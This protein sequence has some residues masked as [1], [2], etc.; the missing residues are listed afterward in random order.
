MKV[1]RMVIVLLTL[2]SVLFFESR[3]ISAEYNQNVSAK[4]AILIEQESG[5]IL[6]EKDARSP[7]RI[8]SITKIMTAILAIESGNL[9]EKV[10]VSSRAFS[11]EGSSIYLTEGEEIPLR[12]LI[13]GLMLRSGNDA[14]VAIAEHVGGS[15]E[16]FV[17]MMNEKASEI[18][19]EQTIFANP[20]GLDDHEE[21]YSSALDMALLTQYAMENETYKE[22]TSTKSYRSDSDK[23]HI[24]VF[25][26]KNR[27]LTQLYPYAIGGKTGYTKRA[28]RT[29]VS[30][31]EK[32]GLELIA[33]TIDA[34]SDW[35][36]HMNL[37]DWGFANFQ[38]KTLVKKG[39]VKD[40][41]D[42]Y[43]KNHLEAEFSFEFPL[44]EDEH[45]QIKTK[46]MLLSPSN[47]AEWEE[48]GHP[49]PIGTV[50]IDLS[51][52]TIGIV[53]LAYKN[54]EKVSTFYEKWIQR[55]IPMNGVFTGG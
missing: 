33:V 27:L 34:P 52:E 21:H 17:Y 13:Y 3:S 6:Y 25:N 54:E 43:F 35:H 38:I 29:L 49:Y 22:V 47:S 36:D 30:S 8:A 16:G 15:L 42:P 24:R 23:D 51:G 18:G 37:F 5:R 11:T 14:A 19:M 40:I 45:N 26:N 10:T 44:E 4:G 1:T 12:D 31:A 28:N 9:D 46:L 50:Q 20:H 2:F 55:W 32:D 7:M 53:P 39:M 48:N 41:D